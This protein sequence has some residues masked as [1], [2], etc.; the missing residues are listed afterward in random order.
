MRTNSTV[1]STV[2]ESTHFVGFGVNNCLFL[3]FLSESSFT[4]LFL[5]F[6]L[7][8]NHTTKYDHNVISYHK[9]DLRKFTNL[10]GDMF[11]FL[12]KDFVFKFLK[13]K[14][15]FRE[16]TVDLKTNNLLNKI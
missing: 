12:S 5:K 15:S 1:N 10:R 16:K 9:Y 8:S 11:I 2:L 6:H 14:L 7:S 13:I 3:S 4:N